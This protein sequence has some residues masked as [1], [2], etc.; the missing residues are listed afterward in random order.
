MATDEKKERKDS[1][2]A[3]SVNGNAS[4]RGNAT[5]KV[6]DR[7]QTKKLETADTRKTSGGSESQTSLVASDSG[8]TKKG[9]TKV[10]PNASSARKSARYDDSGKEQEGKKPQKKSRAGLIIFILVVLAV[11]GIGYYL[12]LSSLPTGPGEG[13]AGG[14]G[15]LEATEIDISAKL[16]GRIIDINVDEGDFVTSG[17]VL[18][19]MQLD[20]LEAQLTEARADVAKAKAA[21]VSARAQVGVRISDLNAAK[22]TVAQRESELEQTRRRLQRSAVLSEKGVITGQQYDDDETT[23]MAAAAAV[24]TA[25]AQVGVAEAAVTAARADAEGAIAAIKAADATVA[26]IEADIKDSHLIA[27]R[28]GRVQY[29]IAQPG[30]VVAAGGKVLNFVDLSDVYMNFF[31][32]AADTGKVA[33]GGEARIVLDAFPDH[34]VPAT[35]SYVAS[36]AQ[37]TP[38][39]VETEL[40]RQKLMFR[41]KAKVDRGLL[42]KHLEMVKT[43]LPGVV[44]VKTDTSAKWPEY[45]EVKGM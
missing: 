28:D 34:P 22:A 20:T 15:R 4:A 42:S 43:G 27:P 7:S 33:I 29:R 23:E 6:G 37:F 11:I 39:T 1:K 17:Q 32:P 36:V 19:V 9:E 16:A 2:T 5:G 24:D 44:W 21:E 14:N 18:A 38:K 35:I 13:F 10:S 25:K 40:E 30:E 41:I 3:D 8:G 31:L 12:Y 45:L 26:R